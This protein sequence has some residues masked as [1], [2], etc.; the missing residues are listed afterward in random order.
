MRKKKSPLLSLFSSFLLISY[1]SS[2]KKTERESVPHKN[3]STKK[4]AA[5]KKKRVT[6][7]FASCEL[8][9]VECLF[10]SLLFAF[11]REKQIQ[12]VRIFS[13]AAR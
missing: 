7:D 13:R 6:R 8:W 9:L 1:F 3:K 12:I 2:C 11:R 4:R 5:E 10:L